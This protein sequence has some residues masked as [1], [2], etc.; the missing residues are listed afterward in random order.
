MFGDHNFVFSGQLKH[1]LDMARK[2]VKPAENAPHS[3]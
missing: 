2:V 1:M 3:A